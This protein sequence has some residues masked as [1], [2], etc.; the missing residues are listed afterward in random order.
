V[1]LTSKA[2]KNPTERPPTFGFI[3][4]KVFSGEKRREGLQDGVVKFYK[5]LESQ[6]R[7]QVEEPT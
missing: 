6:R 1:R 2:E 4:N 7:C 3:P 5:V